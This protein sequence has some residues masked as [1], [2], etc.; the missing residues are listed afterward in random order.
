MSRWVDAALSILFS[1]EV[2]EL[3]ANVVKAAKS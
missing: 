3:I 1:K 2:G